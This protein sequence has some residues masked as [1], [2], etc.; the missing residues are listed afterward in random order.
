M[1]SL[2][3]KSY[4][5]YLS[6]ANITCEESLGTFRYISKQFRLSCCTDT[7]IRS[8]FTDHP[9]LKIQY[10][11]SV[12]QNN[13]ESVADFCMEFAIFWILPET[14]KRGKCSL[15]DLVTRK[16]QFWILPFRC[17]L[18]NYLDINILG[19]VE[20]VRKYD[21]SEENIR[22][23]TQLKLRNVLFWEKENQREGK[24]RNVL[25][26]RGSFNVSRDKGIGIH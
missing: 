22:F 12:T 24:E 5:K 6:E 25:D 17:T 11:F 21:D 7:R 23:D 3:S 14:R 13:E 18:K 19:R 15:E 10:H 26:L 2:R 20:G 8:Y 4:C 1:A 16:P 9:L